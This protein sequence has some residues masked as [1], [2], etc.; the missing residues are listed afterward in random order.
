MWRRAVLRGRG[1][2]QR[3]EGAP[4]ST[5]SGNIAVLGAAQLRAVAPHLRVGVVIRDGVAGRG[6]LGPRLH[7]QQ[8]DAGVPDN[9]DHGQGDANDLPR[10]VRQ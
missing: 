1:Q 10:S 3:M 9:R 5:Q 2:T 7:L 4:A 8:L 6:A